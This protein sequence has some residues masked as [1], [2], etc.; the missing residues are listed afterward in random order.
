MPA[1]F[2]VGDYCM[3][4]VFNN[5]DLKAEVR[6][7]VICDEYW[8]VAKDVCEALGLRTDNL[9]TILDADEVGELPGKPAIE[10]NPYIIGVD[11]A[12]GSAGSDNVQTRSNGGRTP[13][14]ISEPGL[15]SLILKSR[16]PEAKAFK[17]WVTHDVLPAIRKTGAYGLDKVMQKLDSLE[18]QVRQL[19][20]TNNKVLPMPEPA[21]LI[22]AGRGMYRTVVSMT[23]E[24]REYGYDLHYV[25]VIGRVLSKMSREMGYATRKFGLVNGYHVD[26]WNAFFDKEGT[27]ME[28]YKV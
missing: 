16:K 5:S 20:Q 10:A 6:V 28:E 27:F 26:V 7:V 2:L 23:D 12:G 14:I 9:R 4:T 15:Y 8:F 24:L 18:A 3:F 19:Q 11:S 17:R 21:P 22:T 13:L 1:F 25:M